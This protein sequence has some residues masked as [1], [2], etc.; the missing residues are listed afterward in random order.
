MNTRVLRGGMLWGALL[1]LSMVSLQCLN[2][3]LEPVAPTWDTDLTVPVGNRTYSLSDLVEKDTSMLGYASGGSLLIFKTS[4]QAKP[5]YVGDLVKISPINASTNISLGSFAIAPFT[6]VM[7]VPVPGLATG[8]PLPPLSGLSVNPVTGTIASFYGVTLRSGTLQFKIHNN[9]PATITIG[10]PIVL[11]D[12]TGG[13]I[14]MFFSGGETVAASGGERTA[15]ADIS[16]KT[17]T[18]RVVLSGIQLSEPG[19]T[20]TIPPGDLIVATL[21]AGNLVARK[22]VLASIPPQVLLDNA[23]ARLALSDSTRVRE[24]KLRSGTLNIHFVSNVSLGAYLK[25]RLGQLFLANGMLFQDSV[26][27]AANGVADRSINLAEM[28]MKSSDGSLLSGLDVTTSVNVFQGSGGSRSPCRRQTVYSLRQ[29][30]RRL[31]LTVYRE[32]SSLLPLQSIS[33]WR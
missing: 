9:L 29:P 31:S 26:L 11:Q 4:M 24:V 15:T 13:T 33:E 22:A 27:L 5:T 2:K 25:F 7:P 6:L 21:D 17:I 1:A 30:V 18:R 14:A 12:S 3:P 8:M 16:G 23:T 28:K 10:Q 20:Q 32:Y 19:S